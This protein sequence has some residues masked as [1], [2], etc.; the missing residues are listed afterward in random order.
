MTDDYEDVPGSSAAERYLRARR[1]AAL[2]LIA[3]LKGDNDADARRDRERIIA[4]YVA[5]G[6]AIEV[7]AAKAELD[8]VYQLGDRNPADG[9]ADLR[10]MVEPHIELGRQMRTDVR[11][12]TVEDCPQ[13]GL[14]WPAS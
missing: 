3:I 7:R 9:I 1:L 11:R 5:A 10:A 12:G 8:R 6:L 2:E 14:E 13:D 4:D